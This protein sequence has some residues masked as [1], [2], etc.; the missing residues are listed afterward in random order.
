MR[1]ADLSAEGKGYLRG[2]EDGAALKWWVEWLEGGAL[3]V[4][5]DWEERVGKGEIVPGALK[6]WQMEK[7]EGH[8]ASVLSILRDG[9][10]F[11]SHGIFE[12]MVGRGVRVKG[13]LGETDG[14]CSKGD[15]RALGI[16]DVDVVMGAGHGVVRER[17][18]EV[19]ALIKVFWEKE[20]E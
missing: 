17:E 3:H 18:E 7:H 15:L 16:T 14:I 12:E 20:R 13:V 11:D 4:P 5:E 6:R 10:V 1:A 19:A 8:G 2:G 9:G